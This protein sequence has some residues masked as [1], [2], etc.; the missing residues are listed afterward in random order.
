MI[1]RA[2][3]LFRSPAKPLRVADC[4]NKKDPP[5]PQNEKVLTRSRRWVRRYAAS[6]FPL[7]TDLAYRYRPFTGRTRISTVD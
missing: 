6:D 7:Q 1:G 5:V 2:E 3:P 4:Q